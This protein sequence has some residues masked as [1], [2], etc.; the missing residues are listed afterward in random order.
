MMKRKKELLSS[1]KTEREAKSS[2]RSM[3]R[4]DT[5]ADEYWLR[6]MPSTAVE[7]SEIGIIFRGRD[8]LHRK[9][10]D[11][12]SDSP[13]LVSA[14]SGYSWGD[15][16]KLLVHIPG[17][18]SSP[19]THHVG[20]DF[21]RAAHSVGWASIS[22]SYEWA[23][24]ADSQK[25]TECMNRGNPVCQKMLAAYHRDVSF[26]GSTCPLSNTHVSGSI[27]GRLG[28]LLLYLAKVRSADEEWSSFLVD[29]GAE[30]M[31]KEG[32]E[33]VTIED[34]ISSINWTRIILTGHSQ[35]AGHAAYI[36]QEIE[37]GRL[38]LFS[39]PQ[40]GFVLSDS[41]DDPQYHWLDNEFKT[42]NV[43]GMMHRNEE[44]TSGT[45]TF[46]LFFT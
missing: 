12:E 31:M 8:L 30:M 3:M 43:Y 28:A 25:N 17:T 13:H 39:G 35:G 27:V 4:R 32:G 29:G 18:G 36:G 44:G 2:L 20:S 42:K 15:E 14:G 1:G 7:E 45:C 21:L 46:L 10:A 23:N 11:Y 41:P 9:G 37:V 33:D 38:V 6:V 5:I 22:L 19:T 40:E 24:Y 34:I 16:K 26:G